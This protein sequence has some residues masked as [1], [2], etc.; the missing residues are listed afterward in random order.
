MKKHKKLIISTMIAAVMLFGSIAGVAF[1][2]DGSEGAGFHEKLAE[3]LGITP[4]E[5]QSKIADIRGDMPQ[6]GVENRQSRR[7]PDGNMS[8]LFAE[9]DEETQ[10]ALKNDLDQA[11]EE[12][13]DKTIEILESYEIDTEALHGEW[14]EDAGNRLPFR[15][16]FMGPRG[17]RGGIRGFGGPATAVE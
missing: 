6:R 15:S 14:A 11:R 17:A 13:H 16:G 1:A 10:A 5:L 3:S 7:G 8:N 2:D 4:E 12:M 9:L